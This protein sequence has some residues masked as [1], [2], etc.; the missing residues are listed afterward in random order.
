MRKVGIPESSYHYHVKQMRQ[1]Y[2]NQKLEETIQSI[3]DEHNEN[4]GY[5]R[6]QMELK[7][8]GLVVN[9]KK[10]Q[11]TMRKL[12][13]KGSKFT[14]KTRRYSSY[15]GSVDTVVKNRIHRRFTTTIPYQ[16]LTTDITEFKCSDSLKLYLSPMM[17]MYNG[18]ILSYGISI[19]PTLDFVMK[20]LEEAL[21]IVKNARYRTTIHSDQGW[22]YQH[23]KWVATLKKHKVYQS[24]SRKGNCLDNAPMEN[25]FGLLKQEMYYGEPPRTY[26]ELKRA[27][28][29]YI[30][31]YNN[32]RIKQKLA[33]MSPVQ[34]RLHT[35]QLAA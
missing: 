11:R 34:Y 7:N 21:E 22:H 12:G 33:G 30:E 26:E 17:D 8:L 15:K 2:P 9:H 4:Y 20:P 19:R 13:F 3:F 29:A 35:S 18:E 27:I 5:R 1:E 23:G 28:E 24:M 25:F 16:K 32:K 14:R 6:I 31:Y 10:V